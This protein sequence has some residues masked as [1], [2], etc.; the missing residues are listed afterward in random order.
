VEFGIQWLAVGLR[1]KIQ[2]H[3]Q[4][5]C[6]NWRCMGMCDPHSV[7]STIHQPRWFFFVPAPKE[8]APLMVYWRPWKSFAKIFLCYCLDLHERF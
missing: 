4:K 3:F 1:N 2:V 6:A 7:V 5:P 8:L